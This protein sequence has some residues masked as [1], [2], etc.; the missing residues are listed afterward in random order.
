M[1]KETADISLQPKSDRRATPKRQAPRPS[2][3][4]P[5]QRGVGPRL[6][7]R[8]RILRGL[9]RRCGRLDP[10][11]EIDGGEKLL[12]VLRIGRNIGLR[13]VLLVHAVGEMALERRLALDVF[14]ALE[15]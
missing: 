1:N 3:R 10:V 4:R 8:R 9:R 11:Q 15:I 2:P 14:L 12:V 13:T 7:G 6:G 5:R